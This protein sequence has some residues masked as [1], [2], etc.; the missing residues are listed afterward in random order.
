[1]LHEIRDAVVQDAND[2]EGTGTW[3]NVQAVESHVPAPSL[4]AAHYLRIA[5]SRI[6]QRRAVQQALKTTTP[7]QFQTM[8]AERSETLQNLGHAV[9]LST[10]MCFVQGLDILERESEK[11]HWNVNIPRVLDIWK[12]GCIIKSDAI[13]ELFQA[14]YAEGQHTHLLCAPLIAQEARDHQPFLKKIVL[15]SIT[16]DAHVPCLS[17][18]LEYL[19]Y[20]SSTDLPTSFTEAQLDSFGAHGYDLKSEAVRHL[21]KGE[22]SALERT[23]EPG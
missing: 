16:A 6:E 2:S 13:L 1:M 23:S 21:L 11:E 17:A 15:Q 12:A 10:L 8:S 14:S 20:M 3:A 4:T 7:E 18:T 5:S 19:K 9:Y 22:F